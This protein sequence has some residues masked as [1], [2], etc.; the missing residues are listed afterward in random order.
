MGLASLGVLLAVTTRTMGMQATT[1]AVMVPTKEGTV[2]SGLAG[3]PVN[4]VRNG[5]LFR[6]MQSADVGVSV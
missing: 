3:C 5:W 6:H 4:K 1:A 2:D